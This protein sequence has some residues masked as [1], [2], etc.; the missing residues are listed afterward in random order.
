MFS[1]GS[2]A[3]S[4]P[5]KP[6]DKPFPASGKANLAFAENLLNHSVD[7]Y[8]NATSFQ[9]AF[10]VSRVTKRGKGNS[11]KEWTAKVRLRTSWRVDDPNKNILENTLTI[12]SGQEKGKPFVQTIRNIH[13]GKMGLMYVVEQKQWA[14]YYSRQPLSFNIPL[15]MSPL[16]GVVSNNLLNNPVKS[17]VI[18]REVENGVPVYVVRDKEQLNHYKLRA[19]IDVSSRRLRSFTMNST[20]GDKEGDIEVRILDCKLNKRLPNSA[21]EWKKPQGASEVPDGALQAKIG[22]LGYPYVQ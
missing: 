20:D 11:G 9:G 19:V 22:I 14:Q 21:F 13:N 2:V 3:W 6:A 10:F 4:A 5:K 12:V 7:D 18:R 17:P 1:L 15:V 8:I 16:I